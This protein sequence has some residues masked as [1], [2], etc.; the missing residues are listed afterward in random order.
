MFC[1]EERMIWCSRE[2]R[3]INV[4]NYL[5]YKALRCCI[6][7]SYT[8]DSIADTSRH[9]NLEHQRLDRSLEV[10]PSVAHLLC[11]SEINGDSSVCLP[12]LRLRQLLMCHPRS[13]ANLRE[14]K[15]NFVNRVH[16][17]P[18]DLRRWQALHDWLFFWYVCVIHIS[19]INPPTLL[20]Y[21]QTRFKYV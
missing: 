11:S 7:V 20:V 4:H 5:Y 16:L 12:R 10:M 15:A 17:D 3:R 19:S 13:R 21:C 18:W 9:G 2:S 14:V 6:L 1:L 8:S